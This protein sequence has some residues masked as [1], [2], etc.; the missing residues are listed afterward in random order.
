MCPDVGDIV[1]TINAHSKAARS[2]FSN[3]ELSLIVSQC[4][5]TS[6]SFGFYEGTKSILIIAYYVAHSWLSIL[7]NV[8]LSLF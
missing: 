8:A 6:R 1:N 5:S 2:N 7:R 4:I 3:Q